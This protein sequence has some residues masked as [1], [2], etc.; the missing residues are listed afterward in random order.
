MNPNLARTGAACAR[1]STSLDGGAAAGEREQLRRHT[2]QRVGLHERPVGEPHPQP[3]RGVHALDHVAEAEA[4]DDQRC[5]GLDVRAH[6]EDVA[7]FERVVV[8]EQAEQNLSEHVDLAGRAVAAVH[9][10]RTVV[11]AQRP[12][13]GPQL[14]SR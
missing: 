13:V 2:E 9:L 10:H 5:V 3:V 7:G 6:D 8:G 11:A 12:A 4:R 1:L 14:R